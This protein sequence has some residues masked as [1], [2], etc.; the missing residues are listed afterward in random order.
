[1]KAFIKR[2]KRNKNFLLSAASGILCAL[3]FNVPSLWFLCFFALIPFIYVLIRR[4]L[5]VKQAFGL[6]FAFSFFMYIGGM[7]WIFQLRHSMNLSAVSAYGILLLALITVAAI[8]SAIMGACLMSFAKLRQKKP[9]DIPVL[10]ALYILGEFLMAYM[11]SLA[12]PWFRLGNLATGGLWFVQSAS[13][14]GSLFVSALIVMINACLACA[15]AYRKYKPKVILSLTLAFAIFLINSLFG[16]L[17]IQKPK[18]Q[19]AVNVLIVQGNYP[20]LIKWQTSNEK[21][22]QGYLDLSQ[23]GLTPDTKLVVWPETAMPFVLDSRPSFKK[24]IAEFA[25]SNNITLVFGAFDEIEENGETLQY[26]A[27]YIA[28]PDGSISD[29]YYKQLLVPM[30]EYIPFESTFRSLFPSLFEHKVLQQSIAMGTQVMVYPSVVG[31]ISSLI[32][33]ESILPAL[34]RENAR[35]GSELL[36]MIANDSWFGNSIALRQHYSHS[37]LRAIENGRYLI[38]ATNTGISGIINQ[39]GQTV[40]NTLE[41]NTAGYIQGAVY[42][43]ANTTLYTKVGDI[44]ILPALALVLYAAALSIKKARKK[45]KASRNNDDK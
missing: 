10:A 24:A 13:L 40:S 28:Y 21:M 6:G 22:V 12:F 27:L 23:K 2:I 25:K 19:T 38:R 14:L 20:N 41:V 35:K 7:L 30:G 33:Y 5:K 1:M 45:A 3:C 34:A 11:G 29:P 18:A 37:V 32:C 43:L 31:N 36:C 9:I 44:I 17:Y 26:N 39:Y 16:I 4:N 15:I 42:P 8:E